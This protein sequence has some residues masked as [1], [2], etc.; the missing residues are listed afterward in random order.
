MQCDFIAGC[1]GFHGVTR[2]SIPERNTNS[3]YPILSFWLAWHLDAGSSLANELI[4]TYS[5]RGFAL[6]STRSPE[7][8]RMYHPVRSA[9]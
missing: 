8:Q 1:D 6:V 3:I 5:E 9:G 2:P 4:Y 7:L